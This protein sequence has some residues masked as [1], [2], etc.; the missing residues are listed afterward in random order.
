MHSANIADKGLDAFNKLKDACNA[1]LPQLGKLRVSIAALASDEPEVFA[2]VIKLLISQLDL[3]NEQVDDVT[4]NIVGLAKSSWNTFIAG[5]QEPTPKKIPP[6]SINHEQLYD[7]MLS[8]DNP[9]TEQHLKYIREQ[10]STPT[11]RSERLL[12]L[13]LH[14][15][16]LATL[17]AL[18][19]EKRKGHTSPTVEYKRIIDFIVNLQGKKELNLLKS[20]NNADVLNTLHVY[21]GT[22]LLKAIDSQ[23]N[24]ISAL[25]KHF[26][27]KFFKQIDQNSSYKKAIEKLRDNAI[28]VTEIIE[29][30]NISSIIGNKEI[31]LLVNFI[32][33]VGSV[34]N[35]VLD[36][37]INVNILD[38]ES[39][40]NWIDICCLHRLEKMIQIIKDVLINAMIIRIG[41]L[42][43]YVRENIFLHAFEAEVQNDPKAALV[44][45]KKILSKRTRSRESEFSSSSSETE[46][47][48]SE[49]NQKSTKQPET[50]SI[51][52]IRQ[53]LLYISYYGSN[54]QK[55]QVDKLLPGYEARA[56]EKKRSEERLRIASQEIFQH[57]Q[58][59]QAR[60]SIEKSSQHQIVSD[61]ETNTLIDTLV[62]N[63]VFISDEHNKLLKQLINDINNLG[64]YSYLNTAF[65][66]ACNA[67]C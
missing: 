64:P 55:D 25:L 37:F 8:K 10:L 13:R 65:K 22:H 52:Q 34:Y 62:N 28:I 3:R 1:G 41:D 47:N 50:L 20:N 29:T 51:K 42:P 67:H 4:A 9:F 66:Y 39:Y 17:T 11:V 2:Q 58:K 14:A 38:K 44:E 57:E 19:V 7:L 12:L 21:T 60:K 48:D 30:K 27:M 33:Q 15:E 54:E 32:E 59:E 6:F 53:Y 36:N 18:A 31:M 35:N 5:M 40:I 45:K 16:M 61:D 63:E 49:S 26:Y 46:N 43:E 23:P 24:K 56:T